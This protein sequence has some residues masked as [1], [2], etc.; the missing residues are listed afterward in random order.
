[1]L[2]KWVLLL[3]KD[4]SVK[5]NI[6]ANLSG[7]VITAILGLI[8]VPF[9][10]YYIGI[11]AYGLITVFASLQAI[12]VFLDLGIGA[13][14]SRELAI[15]SSAPEKAQE[16]RDLVRTLEI[17]YWVT[18]IV[19]GVM[20]C[21]LSPVLVWW[22][23]PVKL[24]A[25]TIQQCFL[26]MSVGFALQF[27][28]SFYLGGLLGLQKL[29]LMSGINIF[30]GLL[31]SVGAVLVLRYI[32]A[33]PQAFFLWQTI[34]AALQ[35]LIVYI[36]LWLILPKSS[37][38]AKFDFEKVKQIWR[39]A[40]GMSAISVVT[41][42]YSQID[43]LI[44]SR[45]LSLESFGYYALAST[46]AM[47]LTRLT[48]PVF[49]SL[50]PRFSQ[51]L[52]QND[53]PLLKNLYHQGAQFLSVVVFPISIILAFFS[54]E[55]LRLWQKDEVIADKTHLVLSVL[56]IGAALNA[57][58]TVP[59]ALQLASGWTKLNFY[60]MCGSL[61]FYSAAMLIVTP[62]YGAL[63]AAVVWTV[64]NLLFAIVCTPLMHH[65]L[66]T[67]E[68]WQWIF[69]DNIILLGVVTLGVGIWRYF[70]PADL[71]RLFLASYIALAAIFAVVVTVS[72]AS[73]I[74]Y[75]LW[76]MAGKFLFNKKAEELR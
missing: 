27:P 64:M 37:A 46:V 38:F 53:E 28:T 56:M 33:E 63:G 16:T 76:N 41:I 6:V 13:A 18:A 42:I 67:S 21:A 66:L 8:F 45:M 1:M 65:R 23:N 73:Q 20:A 35:T 54:H 29:V 3:K 74:R 5:T 60:M 2:D 49:Q 26:I 55:V 47:S 7:N 14:L 68:M 17:V 10:L 15:V 25:Q 44:L 62:V 19:I 59:F 12:L 57:I 71:S 31:R 43:R 70:L 36:I 40:F 30:F 75:T 39:F 51:L 32:S 58:M 4:Y 24:T 48:A 9:Y 52:G 50:F 69:K 11:E 22:V 72:S 34:I 61:I